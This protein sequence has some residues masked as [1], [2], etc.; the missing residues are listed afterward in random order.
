[1]LTFLCRPSIKA[2]PRRPLP[3]PEHEAPKAKPNPLKYRTI[4]IVLGSI[5]I[6][7]LS[8][9]CA[10]LY[11]TVIKQPEGAVP[12]DPSAQA[13]VS[14]R[15]NDI[16]NSFDA[17][18]DWMEKVMGIVKMRKKL[19]GLAKGDVLEVSIGTGRNLEYYDFNF[20]SGKGNVKSFTAIDKSPEMLEV[21]HE[22]FGTLYPGILGVRWIVGDASEPG[23]IPP[24][25]KS[26]NERSGHKVGAKY[27][28]IIQ[29]MGLCSTED[30][31]ALLKA[32]GN[33]VKQDEGRILL[34]EH[35]RGKWKWLNSLLDKSAEAHAHKF[36][37]WWNRDLV[38]IV[39][40]SELELI[41]FSTKHGGTTSWIELK[42]PKT[43]EQVEPEEPS[44]VTPKTTETKQGWW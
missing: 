43:L 33:L 15:Y 20:G 41:N 4:P 34:I 2:P 32:L 42:K 38:K 22:K 35:G 14:S 1:M 26:A 11:V 17:E 10:Y 25:P 28:T 36:G 39:E 44:V 12:Q 5:T 21:A 30:P 9:Y 6:F 29:T 37:C 27:D 19:A 16:A 40:D 13:D 8:G 3:E 24:P 18:V 7:V 31:V 23:Q